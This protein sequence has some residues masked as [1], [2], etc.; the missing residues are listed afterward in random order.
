[1]GW[2]SRLGAHYFDQLFDRKQRIA[3]MKHCVAVWTNRPKVG[4][5]INDVLA[6]L[7]SY[8]IEV[9]YVDKSI[10]NGSIFFLKIKTTNY[11][12]DAIL[13]DTCRASFLVPFVGID[14][15]LLG[16][17][18]NVFLCLVWESWFTTT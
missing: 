16:R 13:F 17:A 8:R 6:R 1:M 4:N 5:W 3:Y 11:A 9:V 18:L 10:T 14:I 15:Y 12:C 2:A 7:L